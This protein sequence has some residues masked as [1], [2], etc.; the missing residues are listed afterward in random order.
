MKGCILIAITLCLFGCSEYSPEPATPRTPD[1]TVHLAGNAGGGSYW[2]NGVYS[3]VGDNTIVQTMSVDA[4]SV[5]IG[6]FS[7]GVNAKNIVWQDGKQIDLAGVHLGGVTLVAARDN[8]LYG[9]WY[10]T[11]DW[12]LYKDGTISPLDPTGWPTGMA[13]LGDDVYIAGS[14]QGSEHEWGSDFYHLDTYAICW[15]NEQEIFRETSNSYANTIF[16]HNDDIYL[17]GHLNHSPSL[18]R[19]ACYWKNGERVELTAEDQDAEVRSLFV[20]DSHVYA[21]GVINDQAV[22]WK[23]GVVT[24][25]SNAATESIANSISVLGTDVYV[26]GGEDKF[27]AVWKNG[28]K[29]NISNQEKQGEI[30]CVVVVA[31]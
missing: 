1:S 4:A 9:V 26:A 15:K 19:V 17:G 16:I 18:N 28:I 13:L 21:A 30:E 29:Q 5:L 7:L 12:V 20:T 3:L 2:R 27:P 8:N 14:S 25:L 23:D 6:G 11:E 22:Y 10:Q 31:N 24:K